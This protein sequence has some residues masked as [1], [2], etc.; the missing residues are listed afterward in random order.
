MRRALAALALALIA[1]TGVA[2][3][4]A[5]PPP[6]PAIQAALDAKDRSMDARLRDEPRHV[7][8][9]LKAADAKPG[10][11]ALDVGSGS[12]Y[13]AQLLSTMVGDAG[14]VDIQNTANWINQFPGMDP[15]AL[16]THIK[17]ANIGYI[18]ANWDAIP[19]VRNNYDVITAGEVWH[20]VIL[21]GADYEFAA[22]SLY[23]MLKPGGRLVIEDHDV[24]PEM[25]IR[26]QVNLH[27]ISHG[28]VEGQFIKAGF[29][30]ESMQLFDSPYDNGKMNVFFPGVRGRTD[31][32]I[33]TFVKPGG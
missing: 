10:Q 25:D 26:A 32:F 17:R 18:T 13:L 15:K 29:K 19:I 27:R 9:I 2:Q 12:G 22:K 28:D 21:E 1:P 14:H 33:A 30:L 31:K 7:V 24:R 8:E 11:R 3:K 4:A 23:D 6:P 20:D 16:Q 5:R